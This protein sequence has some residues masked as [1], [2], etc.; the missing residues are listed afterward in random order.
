[1]KKNT[2]E[3]NLPWWKFG[4]V[5]LVLAGPALVVVA[6]CVTFYIAATRIDPLVA[7]D[8]YR[9]GIEI[10]KTLEE[11]ANAASLAPAVQAR[12]HA[13]TGVVVPAARQ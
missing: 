7:E 6:S 3:S 10:N 2:L 5:W 12:N 9:K 13:A 8:Y 4:H 11:D 1:M